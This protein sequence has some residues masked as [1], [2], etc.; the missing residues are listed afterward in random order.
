MPIGTLPNPSALQGS[1]ALTTFK[2]VADDNLLS[3][4]IS[5]RIDKALN[6]IPKAYVVLEDGDIA[7]QNFEQSDQEFTIPG[8]SIRISCGYNS[9][10]EVLYEG[11]IVTQRIKATISG[12]T[13]LELICKDP[14]YKMTID[15][16]SHYFENVN[17]QDILDELVGNYQDLDTSYDA[18]S[19]ST[20]NQISYSSLIQH[21]IS[22]WDYLISRF[23]QTSSFAIVENGVINVKGIPSL[24]AAAFSLEFGRDIINMDLE[25]DS[26]TQHDK[27][28]SI[29][30]D[31]TIQEIIKVTSDQP[32]LPDH[33]NVSANDLSNSNHSTFTI[34]HSGNVKDQQLKQWANSKKLRSELSRITGH[35]SFQGSTLPKLNEYIKIDGISSR[36]NGPCLITGINHEIV[37]G[38]WITKVKIGLSPYSHSDH[39][40]EKEKVEHMTGGAISGLY[41][42]KVIQVVDDPE[43]NLRLLITIP[44]IQSNDEATWMRLSSLDASENKGFVNRPDVDDE[45]LVG[46]LNNDI[47][48]GV[49]LGALFSKKH[50]GSSLLEPT[51]KNNK[52]GW[53]IKKDMHLI[54]DSEDDIVE[55]GTAP[56]N[57]IRIDQNVIT[58][59]DQFDNKLTMDSAGIAL[60]SNGDIKMTANGGN[61]VINGKSIEMSATTNLKAKGAMASLEG[62]SSTTIKGGIVQ[63][64]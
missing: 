5:I 6:C 26:Q 42:G 25:L 59:S 49:V 32:S 27:V 60:N 23:E 2:V 14:C 13:Q 64:N 43:D 53:V 18:L 16:K 17:Q 63:I 11:E 40:P 48:Q 22:D 39:H 7:Q 37:R 19:L 10:E 8:K 55:L 61:I 62:D 4:V 36:F 50:P 34:K 29:A 54:F 33:G 9:N 15:K 46:F 3:G 28:S 44:T 58:I 24:T 47:N 20:V 12:K 41:T 21:N 45:V 1:T 38:D 31:D 30:W 57:L 56:G 35:I 52:K 51:E